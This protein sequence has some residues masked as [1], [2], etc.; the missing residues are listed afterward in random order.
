MLKLAKGVEVDTLLSLTTINVWLKIPFSAQ[1]T[2]KERRENLEIILW[3]YLTFQVLFDKE[4]S[5]RIKLNLNT[6][7][8]KWNCLLFYE[9]EIVGG[10][11][12]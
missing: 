3:K 10:N 2:T 9:A 6:W 11:F 4:Q 1:L 7:R 8:Y 12:K 5:W